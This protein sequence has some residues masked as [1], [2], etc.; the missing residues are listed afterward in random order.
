MPL[1]DLL[2][3]CKYENIYIFSQQELQFQL[4]DHP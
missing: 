2:E 4:A 1:I 3:L